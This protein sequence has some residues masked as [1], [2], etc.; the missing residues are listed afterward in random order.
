MPS[1]EQL[2]FVY[3]SIGREAGAR[4]VASGE[5]ERQ[6]QQQPLVRHTARV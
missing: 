1:S 3:F 4:L 2:G 5:R 6:L